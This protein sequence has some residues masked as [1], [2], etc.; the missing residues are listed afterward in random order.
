MCDFARNS[1]L[2]V[3]SPSLLSLQKTNSRLTRFFCIIA[4][5]SSTLLL[6]EIDIS[7]TD[8]I[9]LATTSSG[10]FLACIIFRTRSFSVTIPIGSLSLTTIT[11]PMLWFT[12]SEAISEAIVEQLT[13]GTG[14]LDIELIVSLVEQEAS[15]VSVLLLIAFD[16][17]MYALTNLISLSLRNR[18]F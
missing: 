15:V 6:F 1:R 4:Q 12:I 14:I 9:S 8:I 5:A 16:Q 7:G 11:A 13:I 2:S 10:F 3:S 17:L 18:E